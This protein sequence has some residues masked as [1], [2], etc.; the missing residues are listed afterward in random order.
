MTPTRKPSPRSASAVLEP[1]P[2][3][4]KPGGVLSRA[5]PPT[6]EEPRESSKIAPQARPAKGGSTTVHRIDHEHIAARAY[7]IFLERGSIHGHDLEDWEQ[8]EMELC[9]FS[10]N[11]QIEDTSHQGQSP[12]A[13]L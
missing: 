6:L 9:G 3:A 2:S 12:G 7:E 13:C 10:A 5:R 8:A 4:K 1:P 11:R